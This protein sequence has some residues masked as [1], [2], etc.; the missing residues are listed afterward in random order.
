MYTSRIFSLFVLCLVVLL[1]LVAA[2][3]LPPNFQHLRRVAAANE[4][5][6]NAIAD[7][8]KDWEQVNHIEYGEE[9]SE[10]PSIDDDDEGVPLIHRQRLQRRRLPA[11]Y[12]G[13][14]DEELDYGVASI[15]IDLDLEVKPAPARWSL[16]NGSKKNVATAWYEEE[17][18]LDEKVRIPL[19]STQVYASFGVFMLFIVSSG[20]WLVHRDDQNK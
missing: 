3:P 2:G 12:Y 16:V 5:T 13:E 18:E 20:L 9:S 11:T 19:S 6:S 14:V 8:L 4:N 1:P 17:E 15:E 10:D 7:A